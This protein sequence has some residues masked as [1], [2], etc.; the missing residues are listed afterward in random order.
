MNGTAPMLGHRV[1][2]RRDTWR[3]C[4]PGHTPLGDPSVGRRAVKRR[5]TQ[6]WRR[7]AAPYLGT[8]CAR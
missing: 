4:C 7:E 8:G 5:E 6:A 2:I 1:T 3:N